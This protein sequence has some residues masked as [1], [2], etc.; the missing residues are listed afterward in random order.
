[1]QF[2]VVKVE[3]NDQLH[4]NENIYFSFTTY[5]NN[6]VLMIIINV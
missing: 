6:H 4:K 1:M 2:I 5:N 3:V